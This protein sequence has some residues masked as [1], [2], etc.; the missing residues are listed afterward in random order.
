[1]S[2]R[3]KRLNRLLA[4][5]RLQEDLD[6]RSLK[7]ALASV[8]EVE[9]GLIRQEAAQ[10]ESSALARTALSTGARGEWLLADAQSAVA[11]WNRGRLRPLL[12]VR[13]NEASEATQKF[14]ESHR[15]HEQVQQL[16]DNAR[17]AAKYEEDRK[18]QAAADDWFLSR[19]K[20]P[21]D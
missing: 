1:M 3:I 19:R 11:G 8:A 7:L 9:A 2:G 15:E 13:A 4:I 6:R 17:R 16:A 21:M 5:R 20:R 18:A 12:H 10:L 14:L